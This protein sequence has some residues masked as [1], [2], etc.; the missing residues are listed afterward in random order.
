MIALIAM[1]VKLTVL[2]ML[3]MLAGLLMNYMDKNTLLFTI[4]IPILL[5]TS[6]PSAL[7]TTMNRSV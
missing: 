3:F 7:V 5:T 2:I 4:L 6:V 1:L